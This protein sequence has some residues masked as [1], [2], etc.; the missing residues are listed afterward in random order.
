M[1]L[2]WIN[3]DFNFLPIDYNYYPPQ[4][5]ADQ[6][7]QPSLQQ[8]Q[9]M[10]DWWER[11]FDYDRVRQAVHRRCQHHLWLLFNAALNEQPANLGPLLRFM[12]ADPKHWN[13]DLN[14]YQDQF[15]SLYPVTST[16]LEDDRWLVRVW[17][18]DCW[19]GAVSRHFHPQDISTANPAL[20]ASA[21]PSAPVSGQS[22]AVTGNANLLAFLGDGC[23]ANGDPRRYADLKRLNDG[24]RERGRD[25]LVQYLC[26]MKRVLLPLGQFAVRHESRSSYAGFCCLTCKPVWVKKSEAASTRRSRPC[27]RL[28]ARQLGLE[29]TWQVTGEFARYGTAATKPITRGNGANAVSSTRKTGSTGPSWAGRGGSKRFA[30]S[31]RGCGA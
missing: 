11:L 7:V 6:R 1:R 3:F 12:G 21:D 30:C 24:L 31:S 13:L 22:V 4:A 17:H 8:T 27:R 25:A 29:L 10:F 18:A 15:N 19:S 14:Y 2:A 28:C 20:W 16:D 23:L 5:A 9:A 26:R